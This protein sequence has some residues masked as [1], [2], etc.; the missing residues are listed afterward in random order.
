[1]GVRRFVPVAIPVVGLVVLLSL[2]HG[3][4]SQTS[5]GTIPAKTPSFQVASCPTASSSDHKWAEVSWAMGYGDIPSLT[6]DADLV[7][8]GKI[9]GCPSVGSEEVGAPP[10]TSTLYTTYFSFEIES[11]PYGAASQPTVVIPQTGGIVGGKTA[12][13]MDDPLM[14]TGDRYVLFLREARS[15]LYVVLGGPPGRF[16][17]RD[18]LVSSLSAIYPERNIFDQ[19]IKDMPLGEFVEQVRG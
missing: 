16:V 4:S 19:R 17:V 6:A 5:S 2:A 3:S 1:M 7:A 11:V 8:L 15:G 14:Q 9:T 10:V 18:E 12:E 13:I